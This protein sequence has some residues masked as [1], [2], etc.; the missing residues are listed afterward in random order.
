MSR[1]LRIEYPGAW[2]HVMNR[3]R[4]QEEIFL[5]REDYESFIGILQETSA[6]WN[7]KI[8]AYCL[9]PN[10]Y[11]LLVS[12]PD[13]NIARCMRH[14]NGVYTQRFN[15]RHGTDGQ[16]FR[17][18]YK[19][20]LVE[21][22][23]HLLEVL[24]YIHRNPLRA[25]LVEKIADFAW[26]SHQ[27]YLSAARQWEWLHKDL[28][29]AMLC[30]RESGRRAAYGNFVAQGESE[31]IE[32][33]YSLKSL[34]SVLGGEG[35]KGWVKEKFHHLCFQQEIPESRLLAP[36]AEEIISQ[37]CEHFRVSR[38]QLNAARRGR[39][40]LPR[41]VAVYLVRQL[42]QAS[43]SEV[44]KCFGL[45]NYSTVSSVVE[46]VKRRGKEDRRIRKHLDGLREKLVGRRRMQP[47][48]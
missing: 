29:L 12:T 36:T 45:H 46:R 23:S 2:Y 11:H 40:N 30:S 22:D 13:G 14:I 34:P 20:V 5:S 38:E 39:E 7:L 43:L 28:L 44:G 42:S 21:A 9:M 1:P 8:A 31:E 48:P 17:G 24:R 16:L 26:S 41:D 6:G 15:R 19:A 37:V 32:R 33:F 35:F 25:G 27:G 10:H 18:R 47:L 4:R 3:G